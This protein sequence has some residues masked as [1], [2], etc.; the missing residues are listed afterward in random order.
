MALQ[1]NPSNERLDT[2]DKKHCF[3]SLEHVIIDRSQQK[4]LIENMARVPD[5]SFHENSFN[6]PEIHCSLRKVP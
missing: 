1:E 6:K 3:S 2:V 5:M 4:T